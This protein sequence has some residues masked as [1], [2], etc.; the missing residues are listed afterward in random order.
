MHIVQV[1][2]SIYMHKLMSYHN[3]SVH[4]VHGETWNVMNEQKKSPAEIFSKQ[5]NTRTH[6]NDEQKII[7]DRTEEHRMQT[8]HKQEKERERERRNKVTASLSNWNHL[9][10]FRRC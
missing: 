6:S 7:S 4:K 3:H 8:H 10:D 5:F 2:V 9:T 1:Q